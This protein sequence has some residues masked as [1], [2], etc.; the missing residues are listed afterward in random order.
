MGDIIIIDNISKVY[1]IGQEKVVALR[2]VSLKV[3]EGEFCCVLG[4][5]GSG[6]STLLNMIA[7]LEKPT[8]GDIIIKGQRIN[9]MSENRLARFRQ[10]H[11]GFIFQSYNLMPA[12]T[13]RENVAMPLIFRGIS[14]R[15]RD[16]R[17]LR[18]LGSVGLGSHARHKPTQMSG[19]QPQR[20]GIARAFVGRPEI[21]FADEPTGNL[22]SRTREEVMRLMISISRSNGHTLIMVTHDNELSQYADR[23][24]KIKDGEIDEI[25]DNGGRAEAATSGQ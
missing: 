8:R 22:D 11:I 1:T 20:V 18:M 4:T 10:D 14:K 16:R 23:I 2:N 12:L 21:V 15:E 9:K 25:V 7:G 24:V 19:G 17:A 3:R 6:K 5:S 13:A